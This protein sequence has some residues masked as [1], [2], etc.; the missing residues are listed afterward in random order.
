MKRLSIALGLATLAVLLHG[1]GGGGGAGG[2]GAITANE[3]VFVVRVSDPSNGAPIEN[4]EVYF[5]T[6]TGQTIPMQRVV[7]GS[8]SSGQIALS[9]ARS[10]KSDIRAGDFVLRDVRDNLFFRGFWVRQPSGYTAIVRH[11]T[12]ENVRRVIQTPNSANTQ[13][14]CLIASNQAG[15]VGVVF[16]APR[17]YD[18]GVLEIFPNNPLVPPPPVDDQC[19]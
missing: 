11:I 4:A 7:A 9:I 19:P 18:F 6:D 16:R 14:A 13:A 8:A 17:V 1:C 3:R 15:V 2:G 12:P 5:V 10:F